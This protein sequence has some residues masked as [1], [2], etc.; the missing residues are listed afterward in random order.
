MFFGGGGN[1]LVSGGGDAAGDFLFEVEAV[2]GSAF[3]DAIIGGSA[4]DSLLG[5]DGNDRLDGGGS[6]DTLAGDGGN[7]TLTGGAAADVLQGGSGNDTADYSTATQGVTVNLATGVATGGDA[8]ND[9]FSSIENLTGGS[10]ADLLTGD[11]LGNILTGGDGNDTLVGG[12]GADTLVGGRGIDVVD[13]SAETVGILIAVDGLTTGAGADA[14]GDVLSGI[15]VVTGTAFDDTITGSTSTDTLSGGDGNDRLSGGASSDSLVGGE[16]NDTLTGG[17]GADRLNGGNGIDTADYSTS[18][19]GVSINLQAGTVSGG[20]AASDQLTGIENLTGS[21]ANDFLTGDIG[22]NVLMGGG[23]NDRRAGGGG[24][25]TLVGGTGADFLLGEAGIDT[26]DY[27]SSTGSIR[28]N[29]GGGRGTLGDALNDSLISIENLTGGSGDDTLIGSISGNVL[30][31]GAGADS[32]D[33]GGG[34][35]LVFGGAGN[36]TILVGDGD[37]LGGNDD[38][39]R[40]IVGGPVTATID[41]GSGGTDNDILDL[42]GASNFVLNYSDTTP[43]ALAG[44]V[45]F[46]DNANQ[47][48]IVGTLNFSEIEG[49]V[50]FTPGT[51]IDTD[52]GPVPVEELRQGNR[53]LTRDNGWQEIGWIGRRDLTARQLQVDESLRPVVIKAG[54]LGDNLPE[55]DLVV[56]SAH[57]MLVSSRRAQLYF[58]EPEV[59]VAAK[60]LAGVPGIA[61]GRPQPVSYIHFMCAQHEV[62]R[63]NGV[64]AESFLPGDHAMTQV[65]D[66]QRAELFRLFPEL[67]HCRHKAFPAARRVLKRYEA[68]VL[69]TDGLTGRRHPA[70]F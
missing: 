1:N 11:G 65:G 60:H 70:E 57:R 68:L 42:T 66:E 12:A 6:V 27:S 62:V 59:L 43:G 49:L 39:D 10:G 7:D 52:I 15:E 35:D 8:Q 58:E 23:G 47:D 3:N 21:A 26:A 19:F 14:A 13:Y 67:A 44:S 22:N 50:C 5:G 16:G 48:S 54:S 63:A 24:N 9:T 17:T 53:V 46:Y 51:L 28:V 29:L 41:G 36:D 25:D 55:R 30:A 45:V 40:F 18:A 64:W 32:L 69:K 37:T 4:A 38:S 56:S 2:I 33:G 20:D 34:A 61:Q 31:G